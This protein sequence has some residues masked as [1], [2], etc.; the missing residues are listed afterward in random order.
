MSRPVLM[1]CVRVCA[2]CLCSC[3]HM[4]VCM[5]VRVELTDEKHRRSLTRQEEMSVYRNFDLEL[6]ERFL[7]ESGTA[8]TDSAY[9]VAGRISKRRIAGVHVLQ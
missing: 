2:I 1:S 5:D 6:E 3:N 4:N 8:S 9:A 7:L